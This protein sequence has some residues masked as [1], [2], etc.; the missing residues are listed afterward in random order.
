MEFIQA[1]DLRIN[2]TL[3]SKMY[4][5]FIYSDKIRERYVQSIGWF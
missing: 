4:I 3:L 2:Q 1:L 5:N